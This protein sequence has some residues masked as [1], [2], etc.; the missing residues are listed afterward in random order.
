M[1]CYYTAIPGGC[2]AVLRQ[3]DGQICRR[4]GVQSTSPNGRAIVAGL[5]R[6]LGDFSTASSSDFALSMQT[7]G[8]WPCNSLQGAAAWQAAARYKDCM[9]P[10]QT[11]LPPAVANLPAV[12]GCASLNCTAPGVECKA[13][14]PGY[15]ALRTPTYLP[16][17]DAIK[18]AAHGHGSWQRLR[19]G[20]PRTPRPGPQAERPRPVAGSGLVCEKCMRDGVGCNQCDPV[21]GCARWGAGWSAGRAQSVCCMLDTPSTSLPPPSLLLAAARL[22][23]P[24]PPT[25]QTFP[26][27]LPSCTRPALPSAA[28]RVSWRSSTQPA[29][30]SVRCCVQATTHQ[31]RHPPRSPPAHCAEAVS[32]PPCSTPYDFYSFNCP[33]AQSCKEGVGCTSC[34]PGYTMTTGPYS[35]WSN[36]TR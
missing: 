16:V 24:R 8:C 18:G 15:A 5:V 6:A 13:C 32:L 9:L 34:D 21:K 28:V 12:A 29:C 4:A 14:K 10:N 33:S 25:A 35:Q 11:L 31:H 20:L 22:A 17:R 36:V 19:G 7:F 26:P 3:V 1:L 27:C 30:H 23:P 2:R